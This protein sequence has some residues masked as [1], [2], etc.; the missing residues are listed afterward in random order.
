[1][2]SQSVSQSGQSVVSDVARVDGRVKSE[3][4]CGANC[5]GLDLFSPLRR[6]LMGVDLDALPSKLLVRPRGRLY[7][8]RL[9]VAADA[10]RTAF[11]AMGDLQS[12]IGHHYIATDH[13]DHR[14]A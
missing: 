5:Q 13:C 11:L 7:L 12:A 2:V 3:N 4:T 10:G 14:K 6:R 9:L 8:P 1:M